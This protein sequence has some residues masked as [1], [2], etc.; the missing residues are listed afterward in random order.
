MCLHRRNIQQQPQQQTPDHPKIAC[1]QRPPSLGQTAEFLRSH[2]EFFHRCRF[3]A[4]TAVATHRRNRKPVDDRPELAC[5]MVANSL[6]ESGF[7]I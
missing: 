2:P 7:V 5:P 6:P 1:P 4:L 3:H